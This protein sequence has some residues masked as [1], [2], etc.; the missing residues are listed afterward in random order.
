MMVYVLTQEFPKEEMYGLTSPIRRALVSI[1]A[2]IAEGFRCFFSKQHNP[3][4]RMAFGSVA[5]LETELI[6]AARL[7]FL[8]QSQ[9]VLWPEKIDPLSKMLSWFVEKS[10]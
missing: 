7:G 2:N 1:P 5:A 4:L 3:F 8:E 9:P 10:P 6:I